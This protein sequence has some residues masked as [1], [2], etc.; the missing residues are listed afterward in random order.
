MS[1]SKNK[2]RIVISGIGLVTPLGI[3]V[4][5]NWSALME[6][7][8]GIDTVAEF[9][10][11][12]LPTTF[13]GEVKEFNPEDYVDHK[14]ARQYDRYMH[15]AIA[16]SD[17]ALAD[18]GISA[19]DLPKERTA[20]L[21]GSGMGGMKTF[22]EQSVIMH[23]KGH[24]RVSPFFVPA[25]IA[26]MA[27]GMLAIRYG[28]H[29][30]NFAIVSACATGAHSIAVALRMIQNGEADVALAGGAEA[31]IVP[32]AVAG[33]SSAKALSRRNDAPQ[34]ASRPFD[35][36][37]DGFVMGE[38]AGTLVL[39]RETSAKARGARI[40]AYVCGAGNSSDAYHPTAPSEDGAGAALAMKTALQDAGIQP[41]E[42]GYIN[43]HSTSTPLGDKAEVAAMRLALGAAADKVAVSS[44]KSMT[45]HLLGAAG[46]VEAA[47][48]AL[49]LYHA[50]LPPT[51]NLDNLDP[52]CAMDHVAN[53]PR[54][55]N[56]EFAISNAFGFGGT[57]SALVLGK[58]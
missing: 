3:G 58:A 42:L 2:E 16:A 28:T 7:K 9:V 10:A 25:I 21:V 18:A 1:H 46:A 51:I 43:A 44:T 23:E 33:F 47:Y 5:K 34:K 50:K 56:I 41:N 49:A 17:L 15:L 12:E 52:A 45:G 40:Y 8:S 55:A 39:E 24:R 19:G 32:V 4:N 14:M 20:I 57:N 37:R 27:P 22:Y 13:A 11:A 31:A 26:N 36:D 35:I 54:S 53:Q 29:G 30:A 38:G 6:G 48:A